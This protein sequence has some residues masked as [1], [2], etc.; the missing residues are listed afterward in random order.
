MT[1]EEI[2]KYITSNGGYTKET[3]AKLG[4]DWPPK[5]GW[6]KNLITKK[7][8]YKR[9]S[10]SFVNPK[11]YRT[12]GTSKRLKKLYTKEKK[13]LNPIV[14]SSRKKHKKKKIKIK[15]LPYKQYLKTPHWQSVRKHFEGKSCLKCGEKFNIHIH[16]VSYN[17]R[18][19]Y[20]KEINDCIPLCKYCH[21]ELHDFAKDENLSIEIATKEYLLN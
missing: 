9:V 1:K 12:K 6:K 10:Y 3:L 16:H 11:K 20:K 19:N 15:N 4:V 2:E 8:N 17:N 14:L 18:G 21:Y 13:S 7:S 5:R